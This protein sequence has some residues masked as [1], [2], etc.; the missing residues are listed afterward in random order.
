M[1]LVPWIE[2]HFPLAGRSVF[3]YGCGSGPASLAF[4]ARAD[5]HIGIDIDRAQIEL[6]RGLAA[7]R[8]VDNL[9][10]LYSPVDEIFDRTSECA[11]GVDVFLFYAVLEHM[12]IAE[13]LNMLTLARELVDPQ[14]IIVVCELP[15]RLIPYDWHTSLMPFFAQLPEELAVRYYKFSQRDDFVSAMDA[16]RAKGP[17]HARETLTRWGRGMSFHEF[18]L[19]FDDLQKHVM[20]SNYD[21]LLMPVRGLS[22]E[23]LA[24]AQF[25]DQHRPDLA[26]VWSRY[27][28]DVI[29]SAAP[30]DEIPRFIRPVS[31]EEAAGHHMT[32]RGAAGIELGA[33]GVVEVKLPKPSRRFLVGVN[34]AVDP[35]IVDLTTA[36][37]TT[38]TVIPSW[39]SPA[40]T[41]YAT[42]DTPTA[43]GALEVQM[44]APGSVVFLGCAV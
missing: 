7:E 35:V 23:E 40:H 37:E 5:R 29:F 19:V 44:S 25:L 31:L 3:E 43:A 38:S 13:R 39:Q 24:L 41:R 18:E 20:A 30:R 10:L 11:V 36:A 26:P 2:Q 34:V 21:E 14:G 8:G 27:W 15:N 9:E 4:A 1:C 28:Q 33:E 32:W 12:T 6:G 22:G 17:E 42:I 16:A